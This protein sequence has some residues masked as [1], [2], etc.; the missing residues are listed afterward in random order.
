VLKSAERHAFF[1]LLFPGPTYLKQNQAAEKGAE[2][3]VEEASGFFLLIIAD[4]LHS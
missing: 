1:G 4:S 3:E 2:S